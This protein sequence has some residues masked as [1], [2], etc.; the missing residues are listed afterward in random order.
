MEKKDYNNFI[1]SMKLSHHW[2]YSDDNITSEIRYGLFVPSNELVIE[3]MEGLGYF[4]LAEVIN[5]C[6]YTKNVKLL[7]ILTEY[8]IAKWKSAQRNEENDYLEEDRKSCLYA[9][10]RTIYRL[11][12]DGKIAYGEKTFARILEDF[13]EHIRIPECQ[14]IID[15]LLR[16]YFNYCTELSEESLAFIKEEESRLD[17][18]RELEE[19]YVNKYKKENNDDIQNGIVPLFTIVD[20]KDRIVKWIG[21][22]DRFKTRREQYLCRPALYE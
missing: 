11:L 19:K 21:N 16:E 15:V 13:N 4:L 1:K 12:K 22:C 14:P 18:V 2:Y 6:E 17:C 9:S 3:L 7:Y 8:V 10:L 20:E 5:S